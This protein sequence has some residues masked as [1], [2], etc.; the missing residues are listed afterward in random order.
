VVTLHEFSIAKELVN[1][2]LEEARV[3]N[4]I[5]VIRVELEIGEVS[6]IQDE[7]LIYSFD[8]I[9]AEQPLINEAVLTITKKDLL[10]EC[11][12]CG[13]KGRSD[14]DDQYHFAV[15][16]LRCPECERG[17]NIIEGKDV[18]IKNIEA[19]VSDDCEES[20]DFEESTDSADSRTGEFDDSSDSRV[21]HDYE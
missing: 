7:Q 11:P 14:Y 19:E 15:P 3:N 12:S 6:F 9:K 2:I 5:K 18:L 16:I 17:V 13:Y 4:V 20:N 1:S 10:V 21:K 8:V